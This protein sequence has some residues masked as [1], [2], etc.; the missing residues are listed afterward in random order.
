M[1]T[2]PTRLDMLRAVMLEAHGPGNPHFKG[3][4]RL[5]AYMPN[6]QLEEV[7]LSLRYDVVLRSAEFCS[8]LWQASASFGL[9]T[10]QAVP[11][12]ETATH[13]QVTAWEGHF[14]ALKTA[15]DSLAYCYEN[16]P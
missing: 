8:A 3:P 16:M 13:E 11:F 6:D 10:G 9:H 12:V 1:E 14:E 2:I 4:E 5:W 15:E 7:L